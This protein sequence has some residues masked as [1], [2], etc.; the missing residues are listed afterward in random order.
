M[1]KNF[2]ILLFLGLLTLNSCD[3]SADKA[4]VSINPSDSTLKKDT[5]KNPETLMD[6]E[7]GDYETYMEVFTIA[8][9]TNLRSTPDKSSTPVQ[10][11]NF[12]TK[13]YAKDYYVDESNS[14]VKVYLTKPVNEANPTEPF[15]YVTRSTLVDNYSFSDF[16]TFFSL[17]PFKELKSGVKKIIIENKYEDSE[18]YLVSQD[19]NRVKKT[20][21]VG[22]FNGDKIEDYL[23]C[24]ENK[25]QS[26]S[27]ILV[28]STNK[29]TNEP[30]LVFSQVLNS[31][32]NVDKYK[33][34]SLE[35]TEN[36]AFSNVK[37]DVGTLKSQEG[38]FYLR[39]NSEFNKY[40]II[41]L[42]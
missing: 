33:K 28:I 30:Y 29:A 18:N 38:D 14:N 7:E 5:I 37:G 27:R 1:N 4:S 2:L 31:L 9:K 24:I 21:S 36:P 35:I 23:V 16:K 13:L 32:V 19:H 41:T 12:G 26:M 20:L 25:N 10:V 42:E 15:Y 39:Y 11:M 34:G 40:E 3:S 6:G 8:D 17:S 22:D